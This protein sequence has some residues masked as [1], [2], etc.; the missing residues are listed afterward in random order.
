MSASLV[1]R[2]TRAFLFAT[3]VGV[4]TQACVE[5]PTEPEVGIG[6]PKVILIIGDGMDDQQITIARNYLV[7]SRGR[8]VLD[9]LP[10]RTA[11]RVETIA[12]DSPS[13]PVYYAT[14]ESPREVHTGGHVPVFANFPEFG[15]FTGLMRQSD[16]FHVSAKYLGLAGS[17]DR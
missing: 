11:A 10:F 15:E 9:D 4:L 8:L 3:L 2:P 12:E 6:V 17:I 16:I 13:Q 1:G 7:G 14:N 5:Q